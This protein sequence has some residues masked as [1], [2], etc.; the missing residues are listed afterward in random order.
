MGFMLSFM[1]VFSIRLRM[2]SAIGVV[3]MLMGMVGAVGLWGMSQLER[4]SEEFTKHSFAESMAVAD[5]RVALSEMH[6]HESNMI[7]QYEKPTEIAL[8]E[9]KWYLAANRIDKLVA[10]MLE[11][12]EDE[13]NAL[14]RELQTSVKAYQKDAESVI[15]QLKTGAFDTAT[16][17][18]IRLGACRA[19]PGSREDGR[20][21][22]IA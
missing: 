6:R 1:R 4:L 7:I 2:W 13:D 16:V 11:G 20:G 19:F 5:L 17:A 8:I 9:G 10:A 12:E 3:L 18:H 21:V 15:A 14:A 22:T